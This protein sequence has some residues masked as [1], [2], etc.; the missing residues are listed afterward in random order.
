MS[1]TTVRVGDH[2]RQSTADLLSQ[3]LGQGYLDLAE[4]DNRVREAFAAHSAEELHRTVAD[5][6]L[7]QLRRTDPRR[8]AARKNAARASVRFHL[9][10][11]AAMVAIVMTVWV[12]IALTTGSFAYFWPVW[13]ILGG[14]VGLLGHALPV[15]TFCR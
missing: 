4:Y 3:A 2:D 8:I 5:L 14:A 1:N 15:R 6:P 7:T 11:Y 10:G 12:A 9:A 13:P